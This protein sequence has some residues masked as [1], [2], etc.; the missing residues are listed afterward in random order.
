MSTFTTGV[1]NGLSAT[2][3]GSPLSPKALKAGIV[4]LDL[5]LFTPSRVILL[6]CTPDQLTRSLKVQSV[7]SDAGDKSEPLRLK[8][9]PEENFKLDVELDATDQLAVG[10]RIAPHAQRRS[11]CG[12]GFVP[13]YG[14][15]QDR[16]HGSAVRTHRVDF[17]T[18]H[19]V[20]V[21]E[22]PV[23]K[24]PSTVL[25]KKWLDL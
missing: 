8:G 25:E 23:T 14:R 17:P 18:C 11:D 7:T 22:F 2:A 5:V 1:F 12:D 10:P 19:T 20:Q 21:T 13:R 4:L 3:T 6:Q 24:R 16:A 15:R 9:Q